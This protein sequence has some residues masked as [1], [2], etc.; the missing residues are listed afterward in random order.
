MLAIVCVHDMPLGARSHPELRRPARAHV[1]VPSG[2]RQVQYS[3]STSIPT[4]V[5]KIRL[6][7]QINHIIKPASAI[8]TGPTVR[9]PAVP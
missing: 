9:R 1:G 8:L 2:G 4:P 7:D 5:L 3:A 6:D